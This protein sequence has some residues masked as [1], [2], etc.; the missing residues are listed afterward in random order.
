VIQLDLRLLF[1]PRFDILPPRIVPDKSGFVRVNSLNGKQVVRIPVVMNGKLAYL[2]GVVIG[3][4]YV[5]KAARRKSHGAGYYWR[6]VITGPHDYLVSLQSL[7]VRIFG[8]RGGLVRDLR[9]EKTWQLRF[10]NLVLHRFFT[11]VIGLPKG[12]KTTHGSWSR[13]ELVREF[14]LHFLAGLIHSD[15]YVGKKYIGIIQKRFNFLV[16]VKRFAKENLQFR[17]RGPSVNRKINGKVAG[18][19]ISI[20]EKEERERLLGAISR[21]EIGAYKTTNG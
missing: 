5:S 12:K 16:R 6:V 15:G 19:M 18:W 1:D 20:Y 8:L 9:K 13:F 21:L 10:A 3:D 17:F 7:F 2:I 14:P 11:R 4:G